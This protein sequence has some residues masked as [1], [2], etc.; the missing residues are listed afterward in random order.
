MIE[1]QFPPLQGHGRFPIY[2]LDSNQVDT[3]DAG[4]ADAL[5]IWQTSP[6]MKRNWANRNILRD[7]EIFFDAETS[8]T[9]NIGDD[10]LR[11][12]ETGEVIIGGFDRASPGDIHHEDFKTS[13]YASILSVH[14]H[15]DTMYGGDP[16]SYIYVPIFD[17]FDAERRRPVAVLMGTV[18]WGIFF[19][20]VLPEN[21]R[22][23]TLVV[24]NSC[25]GSFTYE[26]DGESVI[27]IGEGDQ[28]DPDFTDLGESVEL[29]DKTLIDDG[30]IMGLT[31]N[32]NGCRYSA[33]VYPAR[34]FYNQHHTST[35]LII[36][37]T[38]ALVFVF[39]VCCFIFY[40]RLVERRQ[41]IVLQRA[42]QSSA[43]VS[44]LFVSCV[45]LLFLQTSSIDILTV[46]FRL[47]PKNIRDRLM[48]DADN[49]NLKG[50]KGG[51]FDFT[52]NHRLKS[53]LKTGSNVSEQPNTMDQAPI[54]DL[55]PNA[56]VLF[57]DV[58]S[59]ASPCLSVDYAEERNHSFVLNYCRSLG[60]QHGVQLVTQL[61][62]LF[63][64]R[65]S[66]KRLMLLR[67]VEE[68]SRWKRLEIRT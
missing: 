68:Y 42:T 20:H 52:Q 19:R 61:R 10:A 59:D 65:T 51:G 2:Y 54:A 49:K 16:M 53:Y 41:R 33:N 38:V 64:S 48:G 67:N 12:V 47:Q 62:F 63:C 36:T 35:P 34:E 21:V 60:S 5:P 29:S 8:N 50:G 6:V 31:Y 56:T 66:T 3:V 44:S 58:S 32:T 7:P 27:P 30:T 46:V 9:H 24:E 25:D 57:A 23:V 22:G 17:S 39:T 15:T 55:F 40:D 11:C 37:I 26:I 45:E 18:N 4:G 43:I 13:V 14:E 28:H 1:P